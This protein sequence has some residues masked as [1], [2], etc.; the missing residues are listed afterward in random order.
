MYADLYAGRLT[1]RKAVRVRS[2][3][4]PCRFVGC[5]EC[6][7]VTTQG[8]MPALTAASLLRTQHEV[9]VHNYQHVKLEEHP[10]GLQTA[11]RFV[12]KRTTT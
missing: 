6:F 2:G 9:A 7:V 1:A 8:S 12:P 3:G 11:V 10:R 4:F 5:R